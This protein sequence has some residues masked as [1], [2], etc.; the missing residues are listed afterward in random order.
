MNG[1]G[2]TTRLLI[3]ALLV[4]FG[5]IYV[6][7]DYFGTDVSA[8]AEKF[9]TLAQLL[10]VMV[11]AA[12]VLLGIFKLIGKVYDLLVERQSRDDDSKPEE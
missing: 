3:T 1:Y 12:A 4:V 9:G 5:A 8:E 7:A 2:K 11:L 10:I 6:G